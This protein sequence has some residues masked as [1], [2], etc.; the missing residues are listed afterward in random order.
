MA[1]I[2]NEYAIIED[3]QSKNRIIMLFYVNVAICEDLIFQSNTYILQ[4]FFPL[5]NKRLMKDAS[6]FCS[7]RFQQIMENQK[8]LLQK[9]NLR[10]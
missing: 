5:E 2:H 1:S 4:L 10:E 7:D 6:L 9:V 3:T 8:D